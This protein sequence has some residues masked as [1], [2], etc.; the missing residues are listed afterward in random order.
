MSVTIDANCEINKEKET[1][2]YYRSTKVYV[3]VGKMFLK[4]A[5]KQGH[6]S[7]GIYIFRYIENERSSE[8]NPNTAH[9]YAITNMLQTINCI[10]SY[11]KWIWVF[12]ILWKWFLN[13]SLKINNSENFVCLFRVCA[14]HSPMGI[15]FVSFPISLSYTATLHIAHKPIML[16]IRY[17]C[18]ALK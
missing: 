12:S 10:F 13:Q 3:F 18:F 14:P 15:F 1:Y 9:L 6:R 17:N 11:W 4:S 8:R 5:N 7:I 16:L 2:R